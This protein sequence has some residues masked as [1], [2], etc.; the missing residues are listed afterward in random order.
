MERL[1]NI[2]PIENKD[3]LEDKEMIFDSLIMAEIINSA[4]V[5]DLEEAGF[6]KEEIDT[7]LLELDKFDENSIKGILAMPKEL[8]GRNFPKYKKMIDEGKTVPHEILSNLDQIAKKNGYTLGYHA[9]KIEI[10]A[11]ENGWDVKGTELD[12]RD[13]RLMAYYSLDYKDIYRADRGDKLYVVRAQTGKD[14]AHKVDTSNNWGRADTLSIVHK[15]DLAKIDEQIEN[16]LKE[17]KEQRQRD[18]A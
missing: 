6:E 18:A 5:K 12:D 7:F 8:R 3:V 16:K 17:I 11:S 1:N 2:V 9:S 14:T 13:S 10:P 15:I 4:F